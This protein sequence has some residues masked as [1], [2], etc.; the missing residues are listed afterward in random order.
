M[1][2]VH[3]G[4]GNIGRGF[5]GQILHENGFEVK[6]V[7][8][9]KTII[10]ALNDLHQY[11]IRIAESAEEVLIDQVS[12]INNELNPDEVISAIEEADIITTAI[13]PKVLPLIAPLIA[14]GLQARAKASQEPVDVIACE[15]MIGGS[16]F[17]KSEVLKHITLADRQYIEERVGFPNSAVDR[18]VP[19]QVHD[20]PLLVEV[21]NYREWVIDSSAMKRSNL[22]LE[23]V[24]YVDNLDP[25]I[26]RKLFTVNTG[27]AAVAYEGAAL[28]Y[29]T[30]LEAISDEKVE[31]RLRA[32]L[33][34]TGAL[35]VAKWHFNESVHHNYIEKIIARFKNP[36]IVDDISRV[37]RTPIRKL[38]Y[39]ER[40]IRPLRELKS[41]NLP[42]DAILHTIGQVFKYKDAKDSEAV[43]L[44]SQQKN[45]GI[46]ET[47][48]CVTGL[49]DS[50]FV[51]SIEQCI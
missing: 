19:L 5:I 42:H 39:D 7:D 35:M 3:F 31:A 38:G 17:L 34:E 28:G 33:A 14:E 41:R 10:T 2:A 24:H 9:S 13:G 25:F 30:I 36:Q 8:V 32:V 11:K 6:F 15:N 23:G 44:Q 46:T 51:K 43:Q 40:F 48:K 37:A 49:K 12:G 21:E 47:I 20:D 4:A 18:I 26:E 22:I 16:A 29:K 27:H 45:I 50:A 1:L